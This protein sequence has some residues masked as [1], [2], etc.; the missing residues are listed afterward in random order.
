MVQQP[1]PKAGFGRHMVED[2]AIEVDFGPIEGKHSARQFSGIGDIPLTGLEKILA[3]ENFRAQV[4]KAVGQVNPESQKGRDPMGPKAPVE[5][6]REIEL[7]VGAIDRSLACFQAPVELIESLSQLEVGGQRR[8]SPFHRRGRNGFLGLRAELRHESFGQ[9][10]C[11]A[12]NQVNPPESTQLFEGCTLGQQI[13]PIRG[14]MCGRCRIGI[15]AI[16]IDGIF[17]RARLGQV[18]K[19]RAFPGTPDSHNHENIG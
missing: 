4:R 2:Q 7:V 3:Q 15:H 8:G 6:R 10:G 11:E 12:A 18:A 19:D 16:A 1:L 5:V 9:R 14:G 13:Q 17:G